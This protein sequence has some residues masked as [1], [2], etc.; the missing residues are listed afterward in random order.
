MFST[1]IY[2]IIIISS[3]EP[4]KDGRDLKP[5]LENVRE[6]SWSNKSWSLIVGSTLRSMQLN[7]D[8]YTVRFQVDEQRFVTYAHCTCVCGKGWPESF[9]ANC[10]HSAAM[11][12]V[13][14]EEIIDS[15]TD[16]QLKWKKPSEKKLQL[17]PHGETYQDLIKGSVYKRN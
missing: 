11:Y 2:D 3:G 9:G 4:A 13:I 5:H 17:Y 7:E 14:N 8:Y 16:E 15:K 1:L 6:I 10:K 12:Y